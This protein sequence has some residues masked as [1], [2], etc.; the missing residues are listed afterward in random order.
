MK[1]NRFALLF[2]LFAVTSLACVVESSAN[3]NVNRATEVSKEYLAER[4]K[5]DFKFRSA[6]IDQLG[7]A[8]VRFD[9]IYEGLRVVAAQVI[10]HV[11]LAQEKVRGVTDARKELSSVETQPL[12]GERM[13][14]NL[15]QADSR[16][17]GRTEALTELTILVAED[18]STHLAWRVN[19]LVTHPWR[20]PADWMTF[21]DAHNGEVLL[22]YDNLHTQKLDT[23]LP[24][25]DGDPLAAATGV[26][27][28]LYVGTADLATALLSDGT[29]ALEDPGR[30][31]N[32][33][34]DMLDKRTGSGEL[35]M[36]DDNIWGDSTELD[37][38]TVATDA[39]FGA[40]MTW[41]YYLN[42]H[43]RQGVHDDG[44]GVL[45]RVHFGRDYVNA[46]WSDACQCMTYG[47]GDGV[48]SGP[49]VSLDIAAHEMT[50]G[51]TSAT[52]TLIYF[53]ESGGLN[54]SISDIF[55]TAVEFYAAAFSDEVPE[56]WLGENVWTPGIDGDA[57]RY[58]DH[59]LEDGV[60][61]D[62][63]SLFRPGMN[64]HH[65]SGIANNVFY[66]LSEGG[67]NDTS[68]MT[69]AGIGREKAEQVFYRALVA[70][71]TPGTDFAAAKAA[72]VEA[73]N[74]LYDVET[75][76][77]VASAWEACGVF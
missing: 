38:A 33:T 34:T 74:D 20:D 9:H 36:D 71:M 69:V 28:T 3:D 12:V 62:H 15:A 41:D 54:E 77:R 7:E 23:V 49:L 72:T 52:A 18:H 30:G 43:G 58:M 44:Q 21:V 32:Y 6:F 59:P 40:A 64:V 14:I 4:F 5:D 50:H 45:S 26:A 22:S 11:D 13:A 57:L 42:I 39:Q 10:T 19:L 37:R 25:P 61:I 48:L 55:G 31:G 2:I 75:A 65:S 8:H 67:T 16:L 47:D 56:Y 70:Y 68:G 27:H 53:D 1:M 73:A 17:R 46:F 35:F 29:F 24:A 60:S 51:L 66:L 63:Y 76:D